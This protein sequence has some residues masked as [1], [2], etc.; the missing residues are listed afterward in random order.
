MRIP[1]WL[2][3]RNHVKSK[4][5]EIKEAS[6]TVLNI[7]RKL[8]DLLPHPVKGLGFGPTLGE[9]QDGNSKGIKAKQIAEFY[10]SDK[11]CHQG[12][13]MAPKA[14]LHSHLDVSLTPAMRRPMLNIQTYRFK[15][16]CVSL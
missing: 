4:D 10:A 1:Q 11:A 14:V 12:V 15:V 16:A 3:E 9:D 2:N 6:E 13:A 5:I 8:G 7:C